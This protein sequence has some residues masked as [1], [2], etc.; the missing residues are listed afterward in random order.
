MIDL[1]LLW[2]EKPSLSRKYFQIVY[3]AQEESYGDAV[4]SGSLKS[5]AKS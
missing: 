2:I 3:K 1:I 4:F 5:I